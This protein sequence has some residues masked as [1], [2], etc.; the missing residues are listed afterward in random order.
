MFKVCG[1][2]QRGTVCRDVV[3]AY[4]K[5]RESSACKRPSDLKRRMRTRVHAAF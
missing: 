1:D 4:L 5:G 3:G 2:E